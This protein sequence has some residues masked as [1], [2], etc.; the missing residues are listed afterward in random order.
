MAVEPLSRQRDEQLAGA[1]LAA[2]GGHGGQHAVTILQQRAA[3]G[4]ADLS[5][6]VGKHQRSA[7]LARI[8][9]LIIISQRSP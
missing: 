3:H 1:D 7:F 6:R 5:E 4:G 2:V 9:S 8:D